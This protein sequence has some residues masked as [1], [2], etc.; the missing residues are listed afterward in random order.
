MFPRKYTTKR[1]CKS[2]GF[3]L[4][5]CL[6]FTCNKD[7]GSVDNGERPEDLETNGDLPFFRID[8]KGNTIVDEPKVSATL[9]VAQNRKSIF[10]GTIGI[11]FRGATSQGFE[12]KSFGIE[13]WD[14]NDQDIDVPLLGFPEEE[15]W[16][17]HGPYSDKSLIRN[18]LIYN[19]ARDMGRYASR[20]ELV[21]LQID[22]TY[23]GVYVFMEKLKRDAG[24][25]DISKLNPDENAG[26]A[27]T[28]GYILKIDKL[29]GSGGGDGTY[30]ATNSFES[31]L[32]PASAASDQTIRFL[33]EYPDAAV[34]TAEQKAYIQEYVNDFE[35]A[36]V[37]ETFTDAVT[38][39]ANYIDVD[40]FIDFFILNELANN[41][42]GYRLSTYMH[43]DKNKKMVMGPIWD[44]NLAF[45]NADYCSGGETNVWAYKFN[46]RCS[47]DFWL[48][49]IWWERLLQ[50]PAYVV[51]LK[52]R[53]A[54]LRGTLL[55][56][57]AMADRIASYVGRM[58]NAKAIE[59]NFLT[60]NVLGI[61]V[62]PNNFVGSTYAQENEYLMNWI[63][64]RVLWLD[65][66]IE[67]L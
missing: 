67:A 14:T 1:F 13:T 62:W 7:D 19:L 49:P 30:N 54:S 28:G 27:I 31:Q 47:Q 9:S 40:S 34:I 61:Y 2:L 39:Y 4:L 16:V 38:G 21:E 60:W 59:N 43:K 24:R 58:R 66:A 35:A 32:A 17:L 55:S 20:S 53:W 57:T 65:G 6:L 5:S 33:Y 18:H 45:G 48:V 63:E 11:E 44:F 29:S 36:L 23:R 12:K 8:T 46:E 51:K 41:V 10:E 64:A 42:D 22:T 52:Q 3:A 50:D 56:N 37:S 25:I 15:D 26:E